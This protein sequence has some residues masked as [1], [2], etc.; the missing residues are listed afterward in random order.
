MH[1]AHIH[2]VGRTYELSIVRVGERRTRTRAALQFFG[3]DACTYLHARI[4]WR[5]DTTTVSPV[6][7]RT[8]HTIATERRRGSTEAG[9]R[10]TRASS[11][12]LGK[13]RRSNRFAADPV[14]PG[15]NR[16]G[17]PY[18]YVAKGR[19]RSTVWPDRVCENVIKIFRMIFFER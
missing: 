6:R 17:V 5:T 12:A 3:Q 14:D 1:I 18:P 16:T 10:A 7:G 19:R 9:E 15:G 8:G 4:D 2:A 13:R 11:P